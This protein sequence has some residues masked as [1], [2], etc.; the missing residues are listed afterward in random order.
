M[1]HGVLAVW[2]EAGMT[3]HDVV[4]RLRKLLGMK[5]VG[6]TGT[7]DP[8]VEG[9]LV[10]CLGEGTKLV[11]YLMDGTKEYEGEITLGY[12]TETEDAHG[13]M[14][15]QKAVGAPVSGDAIDQA[16]ESMEGRIKQI[17][18]YYSAV[19]VKGRRLYEYAREGIEVERPVRYVDIMSFK[20]ITD[21]VFNEQQETQQW[22]FDV[23]CGKG[24]YVRT[25]AVDLGEKL[26]Y[27]AHMSKLVRLAT[28]GFN[29]NDAYTLE[30]IKNHV[31]NKTIESIIHPIEAGV[32]E[33]KRLDLTDEMYRDVNHG[34]VLPEDYFGFPLKEKIT[35]FY[36]DHLIAIYDKH[37][38]KPSMIK[39]DKLF[40]HY[41]TIQ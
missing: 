41:R 4:F 1:Y 12:S 19:K 14:V 27:P 24:T 33:F 10:I 3:S 37:P 32:S 15:E 36:E 28:G 17:P 26:G 35:L 40:N 25:L 5:K 9:V 18:P 7:L 2:K 30:D 6:H 29:Q 31:E 22:S 38:T 13:A 23:Q 39:P 8:Q 20:R 21:P 11:E 16:M 34:K